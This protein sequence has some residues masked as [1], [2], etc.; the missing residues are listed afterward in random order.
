MRHS[1]PEKA[2]TSEETEFAALTALFVQRELAW[3][4]NELYGRGP[5]RAEFLSIMM[6]MD[7]MRTQFS[8]GCMEI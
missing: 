2:L 7:R 5:N 4:V 6:K 8:L 1:P 3:V